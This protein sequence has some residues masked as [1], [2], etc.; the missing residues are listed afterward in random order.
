[1]VN[2]HLSEK[3]TTV[4]STRNRLDNERLT[5]RELQLHSTAFT[6]TY[7]CQQ[8]CLEELVPKGKFVL[9]GWLLV[10]GPIV[11]DHLLLLKPRHPAEVLVEVVSRFASYEN[12]HTE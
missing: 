1:M 5:L 3:S 8:S 10:H 2:A 12:G 4:I 9:V 7:S 11:L 6:E